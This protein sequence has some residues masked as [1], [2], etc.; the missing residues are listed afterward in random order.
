MPSNLSPNQRNQKKI[1][2]KMNLYKA[3]Y[4]TLVIIV[5][6]YALQSLIV[7]KL[8]EKYVDLLQELYKVDFNY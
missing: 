2:R 1:V 5:I 7:M 4:L 3:M 6:S 8:E